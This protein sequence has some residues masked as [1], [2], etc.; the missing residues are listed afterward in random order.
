[1]ERGKIILLN[2]VS[3]SGKSTLA[4][5]LVNKLPGYFPFSLDDF[6]TLIERMEDRNN[7]R[8]IPVETEYFFH[9]TI[10]IFSDKGINLIVDHILHDAFTRDHIFEVLADY[11]VLFV[12]VHC[13]LG[14]LERR[15]QSRGDRYIGQGKKQLEFVHQN[16]MY[17]IE[18]DTFLE[19]IESCANRIVEYLNHGRYPNGWLLTREKL[20]KQ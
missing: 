14:E 2:G 12:G 10:A 18:V 19:N 13:P 11:P 4:R 17:D 9:K 8:L 7:Q 1:M 15:E 6:D 5:A 20:I 16:T 3:S